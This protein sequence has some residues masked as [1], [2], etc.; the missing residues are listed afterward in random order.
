MVNVTS[1]N[2]HVREGEFDGRVKS[3]QIYLLISDNDTA[4]RVYSFARLGSV[5]SGC[6]VHVCV[7]VYLCS[8]IRKMSPEIK[9]RDATK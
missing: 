7:C 8:F 3:S 2:S 5:G 4:F 9:M 6:I 1:I